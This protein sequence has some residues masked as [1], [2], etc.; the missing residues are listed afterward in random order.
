MNPYLESPRRWP[1]IHAYLIID[2]A[3]N[4]NRA[5]LPKYRAAVEE[6]VYIDTTMVGIPDTTVYRQPT[7]IQNSSTAVAVSDKPERVMLPMTC[8]VK[9]RYLEIR[10][11]ATQQVVTAIELLSPANK[12]G[13]E[14][15]RKYLKK[16]Q[17]V[18]GSLTHFVEIDLLRKGEPMPM[19]G[20][21]QAD[22]QI[23]ISRANERPGAE[24]Y[25]F[26]LREPI[27]PFPVPLSEGNVE[28]VVDLKQLLETVYDEAGIDSAIDYTTQPQPPLKNDDFEWV[29]SL[30]SVAE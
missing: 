10:E 28:P 17:N 9:E 26:N 7:N 25:A 4:L 2:I 27:P 19:T 6:R 29:Q 22:Y 18:L 15:R 11:I 5:L 8:E 30:A 1:E 3:R 21:Q 20:G 16:R 24:R 23:L 12:R 14:G 13:S